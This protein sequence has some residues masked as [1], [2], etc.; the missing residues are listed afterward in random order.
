M[1]MVQAKVTLSVLRP[2]YSWSSCLQGSGALAGRCHSWLDSCCAC[3]HHASHKLSGC[4]RRH[5]VCISPALRPVGAWMRTVCMKAQKTVDLFDRPVHCVHIHDEISGWVCKLNK[6]FCIPVWELMCLSLR[7]DLLLQ[8]EE[9]VCR[10]AGESWAEI[11]LIAVIH[12]GQSSWLVWKTEEDVGLTPPI[13]MRLVVRTAA[14]EE[15]AQ[16]Q[17]LV[18]AINLSD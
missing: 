3:G 9:C 5:S 14:K 4:L 18:V 6:T 12:V 16:A 2:C 17:V 10:G 7:Q 11:V 15:S 1:Y 13:L 8:T